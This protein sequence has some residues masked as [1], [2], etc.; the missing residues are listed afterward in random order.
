LKRGSTS[1]MAALLRRA[2]GVVRPHVCYYP[3][4]VWMTYSAPTGSVQPATR[5]SPPRCGC[6]LL[7][8]LT[9]LGNAALEQRMNY[10]VGWPVRVLDALLRKRRLLGELKFSQQPPETPKYQACLP[11]WKPVTWRFSASGWRDLNPRPLRPELGTDPAPSCD[12]TNKRRSGCR[13]ALV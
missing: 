2:S 5:T 11:T 12:N 13:S 4:F 6:R 10:S 1:T 9:N 8:G 7:E 3:E